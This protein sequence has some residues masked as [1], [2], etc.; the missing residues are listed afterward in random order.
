MGFKV[1]D[2]P[3]HK[4]LD[5]K[6]LEEQGKKGMKD[7]SMESEPG[8]ARKESNFMEEER[9]GVK[10]EETRA[11]QLYEEKKGNLSQGVK[12]GFET[13]QKAVQQG[14]SLEKE[15]GKESGWDEKRGQTSKA[16]GWKDKPIQ[17]R[18]ESA[19]SPPGRKQGPEGPGGP[20]TG[21]TYEGSAKDPS[22]KEDMRGGTGLDERKEKQIN[23]ERKSNVPNV[24]KEGK[25]EVSDP[26]KEAMG[27]KGAEKE[28]PKRKTP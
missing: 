5:R 14:R 15:V 19:S 23:E 11:K 4:M 16:E 18:T 26:E 24:P 17:S 6:T 22:F 27:N 2:M 12:G 10:G 1:N 7:E 28:V 25:D 3:E 8:K 21:K 9:Q 20:K 13:P